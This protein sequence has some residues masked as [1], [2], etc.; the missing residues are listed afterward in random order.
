MCDFFYKKCIFYVIIYNIENNSGERMKKITVTI[1][2]N[3]ILFKYRTKKL[4]EPSLLNTNVISNNELVFS[5]EYL[6]ENT[7]IVGLFLKELIIEK[8]IIKVIISNNEL[9][10]IV[11]DLLKNVQTIEELTITDNDNLSYAICEKV[12]KNRNIKKLNCYNIPQFMI[13]EL[14]KYKIL[15][16][17]RNEVLFT[18]NFM[19]DNDLNSFSKIYYKTTIKIDDNLTEAEKE[20]VKTFFSINRYIRVIHIDNYN[21]KLITELVDILEECKEKNILIEIHEDIDDID[22]VIALKALNKKLKKKRIKISLVYSKD[23]LESNYLQQVIFTTLKIC[24]LIIFTIVA[25]VLGYI[26]YNNYKAELKDEELK[27]RLDTIVEKESQ[28]N[29]GTSSNGVT[30]SD[31]EVTLNSYKILK[32]VNDDMVG[33][34]TVKGTKIDYPVVRGEDNSHYLTTNFYK[35][36]DYNG[37]VFMDYRNNA[38]DLDANTIIY[39]HNRYSSGIMF[40]TLPNVRKKSWLENE[41]NY[42]ITFNTMNKVQKWKIF[43]YYSIKV[44]SDYLETTFD[45]TKDHEKFI[46]LITKRSKKNFK[47]TVTTDDKILT[48]STCYNTNDRFVVHAVLINEENTKES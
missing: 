36:A 11:I 4:V 21:L 47:T 43:S 9:A 40:G 17:S 46:K 42:Y 30:F 19:A 1:Q 10:L 28:V 41:D 14:D 12:I 45:N 13:E 23:Y 8:D 39:A 5:D 18:S 25:S 24:A 27:N 32:D 7:K 33:W 37:W 2:D 48:L 38:V 15:A 6:K 16:E 44:T 31:E 26:G 3:T 34:L 29:T 22:D 20:D 35:E